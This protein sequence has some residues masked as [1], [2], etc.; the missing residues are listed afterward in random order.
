MCSSDGIRSGER[1]AFKEAHET[2]DDARLKQWSSRARGM[3]KR[4]QYD[5]RAALRIAAKERS[6]R[7]RQLRKQPDQ[8]PAC[9]STGEAGGTS[10]TQKQSAWAEK[11]TWFGDDEVM[12]DAAVLAIHQ[13]DGRRKKGLTQQR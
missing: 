3:S 12:T 10:R 2:D 8:Q 5:A 13:K 9:S 7:D 6:D 11:N 1:S 4:A